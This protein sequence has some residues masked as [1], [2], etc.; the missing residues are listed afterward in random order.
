MLP[1]VIDGTRGEGGG[2]ILRTSL[3][4]A[5]VTGR[6]CRIEN[7][8]AR[9]ASPGLK[10]QHL[11]AVRAAAEVGRARVAGADLGS[12]TLTFEP[13]RVAAG[14]YR[15]AVGSAGSATL[16][17]QT[18]LPALLVASGPSTIELQGGTHNPFAPPFE[19]LAQAYLPAL[20]A[21]GPRVEMRLERHGFYPAGGGEI[22]ARVEPTGALGRID[23]LERGE[24]RHTHV[25]AIVAGLPRSIAVREARTVQR[26]LDLPERALEVV[27][28]P[29]ALGPGNVVLIEV[30]AAQATEVCSGFGRRGVA[31]ERVATDAAHE[32]RDWLAAGVP[33]GPHLA[34]QLLLPMALGG[35]GSF[36]TMTPTRHF[37]TNADL[38]REWL[39]VT[40]ECRVDRPGTHLVEV[41]APGT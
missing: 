19:F 32:A 39:G 38:L 3:S 37:T 1:L 14:T 41:G 6:P 25:R 22:V 9:R 40:I 35:G 15:F 29:P 17:L 23:L 8:R 13:D 34:D 21:L 16:V 26:V 12:R 27:E 31:A 11:A 33:V 18:V 20:R 7:I 24:V 28:L 10:R 36:R 4:L 2:Q 30:R 5:L